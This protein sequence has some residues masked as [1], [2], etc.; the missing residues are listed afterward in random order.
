MKLRQTPW[1]AVAK[2]MMKA[3]QL[4]RVNFKVLDFARSAKVGMKTSKGI[5]RKIALA[6]MIV[7]RIAVIDFVCRDLCWLW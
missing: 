4:R 1:K 3:M 5:L 6:E 2:K 7:L